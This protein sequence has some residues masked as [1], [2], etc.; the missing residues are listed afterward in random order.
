MNTINLNEFTEFVK[1]KDIKYYFDND[2]DILY[3]FH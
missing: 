3:E 2:K 1:V